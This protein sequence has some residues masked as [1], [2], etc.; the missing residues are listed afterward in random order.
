MSVEEELGE[1]ENQERKRCLEETAELSVCLYRK[2]CFGQKEPSP[3]RH[4]EQAQ[5]AVDDRQER[6]RSCW[7]EEEGED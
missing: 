7:R 3:L 4:E 2:K 5:A 6:R 1:A